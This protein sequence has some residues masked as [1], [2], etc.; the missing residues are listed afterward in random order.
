MP[1]ELDQLL[2][3]YTKAETKEMRRAAAKDRARA[4]ERARRVAERHN[5]K[6]FLTI[7]RKSTRDEMEAR[8]A[9]VPADTRTV[10]GVAFGDPLPGRSALDRRHA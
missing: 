4:R 6:G 9:T 7:A 10:T 1:V 8:L 5:T 3:N 2:A